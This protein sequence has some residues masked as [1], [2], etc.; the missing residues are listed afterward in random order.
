MAH[1]RVESGAELNLNVRVVQNPCE[2]LR[3]TLCRQALK[4]V[5]REEPVLIIVADGNALDDSRCHVLELRAPHLQCIGAKEQLR[6]LGADARR[7]DSAAFLGLEI[8]SACCARKVRTST[9]FA[10]AVPKTWFT[11]CRFTGNGTR[12]PSGR[13]A[14]TGVIRHEL[15]KAPQPLDNVHVVCMEQMRAIAVYT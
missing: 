8:S 5:V 12:A 14:C 4:C 10:S 3:V 11:V 15:C 6:E 7:E 9:S 2:Q 13:R 1:S